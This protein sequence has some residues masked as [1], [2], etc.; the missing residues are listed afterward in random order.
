[1]IGFSIMLWFCSAIM[2]ILSISLL[3]GNYASMHGKVF[4]NTADKAGYAKALGKPVLVLGI[5][6]ASAGA[7][8][9]VIQGIYS[10]IISILV[11]LL[12]IVIVGVWFIKIQRQF[13]LIK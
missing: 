4:D 3:R 9:V 10:I 12:F 2:I 8:A 7:A 5:G 13:N 11:L 6:I 1:M